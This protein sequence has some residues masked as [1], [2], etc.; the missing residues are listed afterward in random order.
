[1]NGA[2]GQVTVAPGAIVGALIAYHDVMVGIDNCQPATA[3][4]IRVYPPNQTESVVVPDSL[5]VCANPAFT[6]TASVSP[7][8]LPANLHP[9]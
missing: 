9:G 7:V 5:A 8:A 6:G 3:A 4:G 2:D 1:M